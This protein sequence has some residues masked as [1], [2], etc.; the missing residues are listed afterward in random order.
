MELRRESRYRVN[1]PAHIVTGDG[2]ILAVDLRN[3]SANGAQTTH[4]VVDDIDVGAPLVLAGATMPWERK[5]IVVG[6]SAQGLHLH[7][8]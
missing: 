7:F 8:R 5:A 1:G 3:L 6:V 2:R 4:P